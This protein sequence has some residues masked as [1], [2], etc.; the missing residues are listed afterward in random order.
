MESDNDKAIAA[1]L[2]DRTLT[3]IG[4]YD[5]SISD[6]AQAAELTLAMYQRFLRAIRQEP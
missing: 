1:Q 5:E 3:A 6:P 2:V 4:G